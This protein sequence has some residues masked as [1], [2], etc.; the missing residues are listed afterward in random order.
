D[1]GGS[2][3]EFVN[4]EFTNMNQTGVFIDVRSSA[5]QSPALFENCTFHDADAI[6]ISSAL[7]MDASG[8]PAHVYNSTFYNL[9]MTALSAVGSTRA[10][11]QGFNLSGC[12]IYNIGSYGVLVGGY[13]IEG[14]LY[15]HMY[16]TTIFRTA[17]VRVEV[18]QDYVNAGAQ[19]NVIIINCSVD[20]SLGAG[21]TVY[22]AAYYK[23]G[24]MTVHI[25]NTTVT[26]AAGDGILIKGEDTGTKGSGGYYK[27]KW[28][29]TVTIMG[30][31]ISNVGGIGLA[32]QSV[33]GGALNPGQ[34]DVKINY[35][36]IHSAQRGLFMY[37]FMGTAYYCSVQNTV[38]E[39]VYVLDGRLDMHYCTFA[40]ITDRKF[41][42]SLDASIHFYYDL[43][44]IVRW[45]TGAAALG[46]TV[47]IFDNK[48]TLIAVLP[49]TRHDGR[50]PTFKMVPY[51]VKETG[52]FSD[53]PYVIFTNF[54]QVKKT[55]G[56]KLDASKMVYIILDDHINPE[57]F[58][59]YPKENHIQQ[60]T[61]LKI[62]GSAW[63][64]QSGIKEVMLTLDGDNWLPATGS[65][66][67]NLTIEVSDELIAKFSG[68]FLLR[69]K[70]I[71][72]ALNEK[73]TFVMIRVDP[74]PPELNVDH[75]TEGFVT[76]NPELWVRGVTELGSTV[77]IN[78]VKV[79]VTISMFTH[80]VTLVEGPN[81]I[82]V[83]SID[84]LG[85]IQI[86][87][88]TVYL[89][90]QE[91]YIILISP[92]EGRAMTNEDSIT[93][94]ATVEEE[95]YITVNGYHVPYDSDNYPVGAGI[96]TYD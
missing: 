55:V 36:D 82:S 38:K 6:G 65:L 75:P 67:W 61:T 81:T 34:R 10:S 50:L 44:I 51:Y 52:I 79:D 26:D 5:S 74:T 35:T 18:S 40:G 43:D 60:S 53:T 62:R 58:I 16:N 72:N 84:P 21:I 56:V 41:K 32:L 88:L 2:E 96:L 17:G 20:E 31:T 19:I 87:R 49:V 8:T 15:L 59:L 90:T 39:D 83:I 71:D 95:L 7:Q 3:F 78:S 86:E 47:Q 33:G 94:E 70:A 12:N 13:M 76:N 29:A 25:I 9:S 91:P 45:D 80:M 11:G 48:E 23:P 24:R 73:T 57:I 14:P 89:D 85:N 37:G 22:G 30:T 77:E 54:L 93:I 46:A 69:A 27:P 4:C 68:L 42:A 28:D 1:Y 63:D 64:S 92:E 66:S